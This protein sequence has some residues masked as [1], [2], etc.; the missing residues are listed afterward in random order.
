MTPAVVLLQRLK[1][2]HRTLEYQVGGSAEG[3]G[4]GIEA[5]E[6]LGLDPTT[7]GKTLLARLDDGTLVVAVVPVSHMLDLKGLARAAGTKNPTMADPA[8]AERSSGYV[9]GGISP[10]G[11]RKRLRTFVDTLLTE[12]DEVHV[13]GGRRG[14]E[15]ALAPADLV[16]ATNATVAEVRD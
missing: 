14:L 11:Q 6:A 13:S 5:I 10:L 8:D 3:T 12:T 7:C 9:V 2:A 15:V 16:A 1:I 4:Y